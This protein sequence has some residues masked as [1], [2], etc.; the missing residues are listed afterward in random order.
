[1]SSDPF[2]DAAATI[3][4][5][6]VADA[7]WHDGR[8]SWM[9]AVVEPED[10]SRPEY[11]PLG[12]TIY[13]GT[14]GV[15][16]FLARLF[17]ETGEP[18]LRR[19]AV[20]AIRHAISRAG[21]LPSEQRDGLQA[22]SL[23]IGFAAARTGALLGAEE[24][25]DG[26]RTVLGGLAPAPR[27]RRCPDLVTGAAGS[28]VALLGLAA[29]LGHPR[30]VD[31]ASSVGEVLLESAAV[32]RYGLSWVDPTRRNP[33]HLIGAAHGAGGIGWALIELFAA[34]RDARFATAALDAFAY[35]R[36]WL[37]PD[38]ETWPDLRQ[39]T[40]RARP[41]GPRMTATWCYGE[42]GIALCRRRAI[43][44]L[45]D[46]PHELDAEI[47]VRTTRRHLEDAL[48]FA[49]D[50]LSLCHG[51]G[52][53]ADVLVTAGDEEVA[54]AL[55]HVAIE[56]HGVRGDWPCGVYGTTPG[57]FR[58]LSGIAWLFL[59]LHDPGIPSPL[60]LPEGR[61]TGVVAEQYGRPNH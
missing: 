53:A 29:E 43:E 1:M 37:D 35:E 28:A 16:L 17:A 32:S 61:L 51:A 54:A 3:G 48:P 7:V 14:A 52:G 60:A 22:G 30:L 19:T 41:I 49:I 34:T 6:L 31:A 50:D 10:R 46:G 26:A 21:A 33:H 47:A 42:A 20:G 12:P 44:V 58:G 38:S 13:D 45:G 8:C 27:P 55:A 39:P 40:R 18:P 23:G 2:L 59:R 24:L 36:S 5:Q 15:G 9:G 57:L 25:V 4:R 11:R 56:R